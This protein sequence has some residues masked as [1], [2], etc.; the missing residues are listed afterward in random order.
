MQPAIV[1]TNI[2][3]THSRRCDSIPQWRSGRKCSYLR[4]H[5]VDSHAKQRKWWEMLEVEKTTV[6][7]LVYTQILAR[8]IWTMIVEIGWE[9][10]DVFSSFGIKSQSTGK[11]ISDQHTSDWS[12]GSL[13]E[14][15]L[16]HRSNFRQRTGYF[17][18]I[19]NFHPI[20]C[21]WYAKFSLMKVILSNNSSNKKT[22]QIR[23]IMGRG[24]GNYRNME[25]KLWEN[26]G[27]YRK[28]LKKIRKME[29]VDER[30]K[31]IGCVRMYMRPF[32]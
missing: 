8:V 32:A 4:D 22:E 13:S 16:L 26:V 6:K 20:A 5:K 25:G 15:L 24:K 23:R 17:R 31:M 27:K 3:I 1:T 12:N 21:N 10:N 30:R 29:D 18:A 2:Y 9:S 7:I 11:E 19:Q 14:M 28:A